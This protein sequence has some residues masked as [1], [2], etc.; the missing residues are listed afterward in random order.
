MNSDLLWHVSNLSSLLGEI[1]ISDEN[2]VAWADFSRINTSDH[3]YYCH[4]EWTDD[5]KFSGILY[6]GACSYEKRIAAIG[7]FV[8]SGIPYEVRY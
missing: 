3:D 4:L 6:D 7:F 8:H 1:T 5:G 2:S